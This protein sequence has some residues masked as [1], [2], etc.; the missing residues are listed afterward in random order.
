M[1]MISLVVVGSINQLKSVPMMSLTVVGSIDQSNSGGF[2]GSLW[3]VSMGSLW[4][5][6]AVLAGGLH[7]WSV[8]CGG[9]D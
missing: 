9:E 2:H 8:G 7:G 4:V 3:V 6:S 1:P 5:V